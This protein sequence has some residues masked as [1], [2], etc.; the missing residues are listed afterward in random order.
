MNSSGGP[1]GT[2]TSYNE[3]FLFTSWNPTEWND[4]DALITISEE[5]SAKS[6]SMIHIYGAEEAWA[7]RIKDVSMAG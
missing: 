1:P 4:V 7:L 5:E 2:T 6:K 3:F